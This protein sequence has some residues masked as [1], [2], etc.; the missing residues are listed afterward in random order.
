MFRLMA[1]PLIVGIALAMPTVASAELYKWVDESGTVT[2][3][4]SPPPRAKSVRVLSK[5]SGS[6]SV[7]PGL[8]PE[9]LER[10]R[11]KAQELR[12]RRLEVEL[13]ELRLREQALA[14][15]QRDFAYAEPQQSFAYGGGYWGGG[16]PVGP[17]W[18]DGKWDK[19]FW[20]KYPAHRARPDLDLLPYQRALQ[21]S[22]PQAGMQP[23]GSRR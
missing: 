18:R 21:I 12:L 23:G 16:Y 13:E 9:Q 2:Y 6:L 11:D 1:C 22:S 10:M 19:R 20:P 4:D 7:V 15:A 5:E 3:G 17:G 14:Q 8:A